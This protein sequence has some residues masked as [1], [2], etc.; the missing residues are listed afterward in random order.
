LD[1]LEHPQA[2]S[3][4][5]LEARKTIETRFDWRL[6]VKKVLEVYAETVCQFS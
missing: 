5:A 1:Y 4:M 6:I 2:A 3:E